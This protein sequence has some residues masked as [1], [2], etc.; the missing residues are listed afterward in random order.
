V[1][2]SK[3]NLGS[4]GTVPSAAHATTADAA[5]SSN[6][7]NGLHLARIAFTPG[8]GTPDT[9]FFS[10]AGLTL[11]ASCDSLEE[12]LVTATTSVSNAEI[13]ESGNF[14]DEYRGAV[15]EDFDVG[16]VEQVSENI[17]DESSEANQGQLVY[18]TPAGAVVTIQFSLNENSTHGETQPGCSV[19]GTAQYS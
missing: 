13:Y 19:D 11:R 6:A 4:I 18:S 8:P 16:D 2:G 5:S 17:G 1:T 7:V 14:D 12:L 3:L 9:P 10:A 15:D